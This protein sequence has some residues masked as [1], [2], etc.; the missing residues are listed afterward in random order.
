MGPGITSNARDLCPC[1]GGW[2]LIFQNLRANIFDKGLSSGVLVNS[3]V[4]SSEIEFGWLKNM[5]LFTP[6][7]LLDENHVSYRSYVHRFNSVSPCAIE[8]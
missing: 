5:Y 2:N 6:S 1:L 8:L 3:N 4:L 7:V